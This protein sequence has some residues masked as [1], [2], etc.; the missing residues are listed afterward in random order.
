MHF[1]KSFIVLTLFIGFNSCSTRASVGDINDYVSAHNCD[2]SIISLMGN[3]RYSPHWSY[4]EHLE[5]KLDS[6]FSISIVTDVSI[7]DDSNNNYYGTFRLQ[8]D[9]LYL[10]FAKPGEVESRYNPSR[11]WC[12]DKGVFILTPQLS[13]HYIKRLYDLDDVSEVRLYGSIPYGR[14]SYFKPK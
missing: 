7:E 10:I 2:Y 8:N 9:T 12:T 13:E 3:Y 4:V 6:T 5:L 1:G 11:I 14:S